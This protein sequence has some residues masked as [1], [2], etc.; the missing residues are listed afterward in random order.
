MEVI[1]VKNFLKWLWIDFWNNCEKSVHKFNNAMRRYY[2]RLAASWV[3]QSEVYFQKGWIISL[4]SKYNELIYSVDWVYVH[5]S[6]CRNDEP[7][8]RKEDKCWCDDLYTLITHKAVWTELWLWDYRVDWNTLRINV[9][10]CV[11]KWWITY[12]RWPKII[13]SMDDVVHI[14]S[15]E[16]EIMQAELLRYY[17][18]QNDNYNWAN[19][20]EQRS[21][22]AMQQAKKIVNKIPQTIWSWYTA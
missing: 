7:C 3:T 18:E 19:Y 2:S 22:K 21:Y 20:F 5:L 1:K 12:S 6:Q 8:Y 15:L 9:G 17:H 10:D 13:E 16:S 11:T 14:D 4:S